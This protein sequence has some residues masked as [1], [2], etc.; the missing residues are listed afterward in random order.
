MYEAYRNYYS[1]GD[2]AEWNE[3]VDLGLAIKRHDPFVHKDVV[4]HLTRK[5]LEILSEIL[6]I[7]IT[8]QR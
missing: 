1:T 6:G 4:Y 7:S 2:D 8:Q 5:G 3:L